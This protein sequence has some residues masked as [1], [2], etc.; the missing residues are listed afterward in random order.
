MVIGAENRHGKCR[1]VEQRSVP[2]TCRIRYVRV[3]FVFEP[4]LPK[5]GAVDLDMKKLL[6]RLL[7]LVAGRRY[8]KQQARVRLKTD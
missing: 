5:M 6:P 3:D 1:R 8:P 7:L 4:L 2:G